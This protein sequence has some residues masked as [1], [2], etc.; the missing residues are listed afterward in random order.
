[1]ANQT[2]LITG[3]SAGLGAH[4]ATLFARDGYDVIVVA[5]SQARLETMAERLRQVHKAKVHVLA[6][7]LSQP[8]SGLTLFNECRA[9]SL[10][11][12]VLV[13]NAGFGSNG[14]FLDQALPRELEMVRLN[15]ETLLELTYLFANDMRARGAGQVLNIASTAG[16]Q[17]G[18]YMATYYATKAFVLSFTE[19]LAHE[20]RGTGV[21]VTCHCPGPTHTEFAARAGNDKSNLFQMGGAAKA[22]DVAEHAYEAMKQGEVVSIH[23][24]MNWLAVE[25]VRFAPRALI[26]SI[27]ATLNSAKLDSSPNAR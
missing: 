7:D 5:R 26:R 18:P 16:F 23:G 13:N 1:M 4:F 19:A 11:V 27:S 12:D 25:A 22:E 14:T 21:S 3:A 24:V 9:K 6:A 15:C 17:P 20:L 2:A 10:K 8:G